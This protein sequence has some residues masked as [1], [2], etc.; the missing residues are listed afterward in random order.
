LWLHQLN[1]VNMYFMINGC[2]I[3]YIVVDLCQYR[4]HF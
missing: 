2:T 4:E 3:L 1:T